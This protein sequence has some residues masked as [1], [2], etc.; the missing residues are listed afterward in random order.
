MENP[1]KR[2]HGPARLFLEPDGSRLRAG[3]RILGQLCLLIF[4]ITVIGI[5]ASL[6]LLLNPSG[7]AVMVVGE[8]ATFLAVF[9]SV[10]LARRLLDRRSFTSLGL[11]WD[12]FAGR[13]LLVE[14]FISACMIGLIYLLET[15]TGWLHFERFNLDQTSLVKMLGGLLA[16]LGIFAVTGLTEELMARGYWLRN[17]EEGLGLPWAV[18][19]SSILFALA[20]SLNPNVSLMAIIGLVAAGVFLAFACLRTRQ[21]WLPIGLHIGWN[22]FEGP[23]FG[24]QVSGLG[25]DIRLLEH[26]DQGPALF[27]GGAFGPEAGLVQ[28]F[29][30][31]LGA[32]LVY[33]YTRERHPQQPKHARSNNAAQDSS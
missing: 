8:A 18:L 5:P 7:L 27:T 28:F 11:V 33:F 25:I 21:L 19:I 2:S 12:R 14:F 20:H 17:L 16:L 26:T 30:L 32:L 31:L 6:L 24:F 9:L 10:Y 13:D 3:W 4:F 1:P 22:F 29:A 15:A 23:F